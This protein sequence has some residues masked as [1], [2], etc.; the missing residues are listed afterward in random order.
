MDAPMSPPPERMSSRF[1][2][3]LGDERGVAIMQVMFVAALLA[4]VSYWL[5]DFLMRNDR[6][7]LGM[8][9]RNEN[10]TYSTLLNDNVTDSQAIKNSAAV[11]DRVGAGA[12]IPYD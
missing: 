2:S 1:G 3:V 4:I 11:L 8:I 7:S 10:I 12:E 5:A 6:S 9:R